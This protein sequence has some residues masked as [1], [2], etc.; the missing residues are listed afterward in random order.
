MTFL[1]Q[2][3]LILIAKWLSGNVVPAGAPLSL[4]VQGHHGQLLVLFEE[5]F[6][7]HWREEHSICISLIVIRVEPFKTCLS[8]RFLFLFMSF[9]PLSLGTLVVF[10]IFIRV[11][12][13]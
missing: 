4:A 13:P 12:F 3:F 7:I 1:G 11:Q 9:V 6:L 2:R 10:E 5:S 8:F